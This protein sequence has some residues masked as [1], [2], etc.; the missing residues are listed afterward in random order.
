[1]KLEAL[2]NENCLPLERLLLGLK[3]YKILHFRLQTTNSS[4]S[5]SKL[6]IDTVLQRN[7]SQEAH[8]LELP[9]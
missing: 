2:M 8:I 3:V 5:L 4:L 1:M 6:G 7:S 9:I